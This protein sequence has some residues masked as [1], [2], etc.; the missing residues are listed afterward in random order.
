MLYN[1]TLILHLFIVFERLKTDEQKKDKFLSFFVR[2][3]A[4]SASQDHGR[5]KDYALCFMAVAG[6]F[7]MG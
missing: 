2:A 1:C 7:S 5:L 3:C 4:Q 6:G